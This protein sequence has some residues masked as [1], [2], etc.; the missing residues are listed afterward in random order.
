[1]KTPYVIYCLQ[2]L[3]SIDKIPKINWAVDSYNSNVILLTLIITNNI[4]KGVITSLKNIDG[5]HFRV[6]NLG[7]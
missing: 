5:G 4:L 7:F 3:F 6:L 1:M 2:I